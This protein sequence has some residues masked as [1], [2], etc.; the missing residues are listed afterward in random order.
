MRFH[1]LL[2]RLYPASFR[3]EYG[4][5]L[6]RLF[7]ARRRD[8]QAPFGVIA[9][10]M[11]EIADTCVSAARVHVDILRQDLRHTRRSLSRSRGFALA[12]IVVTALGVGATTA[13]F[14]VADH[15]LLQ[16]LPFAEPDR[17]VKIW[18]STQDYARMDVSPANYRDWKD[19]ARSF[20]RMGAYSEGLTA[21]LTGSGE[22]MRLTGSIVTADLLPVL[23]VPPARGRWFTP[24]EDQPNAPGTVL[25]SDA[26]WRRQF[27]ADPSMIGRAIRL[28]DEVCTVIGIMPASFR[29][30]T[31]ATD[32]W[33]ASR[34][35]A[36]IFADRNNNFLRAMAR[37][38]P[39]VTRDQARA[40]LDA[41]ARD[42]AREY[43][44]DNAKV[45]ATMI[46]M[47]DEVGAQSRLLL[48]TLLGASACI[49][50]IACTNLASLLIARAS[51]REREIAVRTALGAGR[52][53]LVRQLLTESGV[54]AVM[55]GVLGVVFALA[56]VP[57][58]VQL[59]PTSL[60][61][62]EQP[63]VSARMLAIAAGLTLLTGL[64]FGVLPALRASRRTA[65]LRDGVRA[66]VSRRTERL[67][68]ALV[69]AQ[70]AVSVVLLVGSGLMLRALWKVQH[71]DPGFAIDNV[72]TLR[73][74]LPGATYGDQ[75]PRVAFYRR[76]LD[77]VR[78]VPGVTGAAFASWLP[79]TMRGG[80]WPVFL[81]GQSREP[82][83][84][85]TV[86]VRYIT[87]DFFSVLHVPLKLGRA[88]TERDTINAEKTAIV[89]ESFAKAHWP[90]EDPRGKTFFLAFFDRTVVG[91]A[92][93]VRVRGLER[94]S[95][96][97]VYLPY[98]QQLDNMMTFYMPKDLAIGVSDASK[99]AG[100]TA[101]VRG[102]ISAADPALP[103]AD[104]RP[105]SAIVALD[106]VARETQVNV[107]GAFA[108]LACLLAAIGLHGLLAFIVAA[109]SREMGVRLALG[110]APAQV[111]WL[112]MQR[113]LMLALAGVTVG[114]GLALLAG[115]SLDS[116]LSGVS[117]NDPLS[118]ATAVAVTLIGA[119]IGTVMPARRAARTQPTEALRAD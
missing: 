76:V 92:G 82:A 112:V 57:L 33:I 28:N 48:F 63:G 62:A 61:I 5:E 59:V 30:P 78:A 36:D 29:F 6:R 97:Q 12:A 38:K 55:G 111:R 10:W 68:G 26:L 96:P 91:V 21:S 85:P 101:A 113:G 9:L 93:N 71:V 114:V 34:F 75:A 56:A 13:A 115:R 17:I 31:R 98:Q 108:V 23:G 119:M 39:G 79:M 1:R 11:G 105:L 116:L 19:R 51:A 103:I 58:I 37:L 44:A 102:I 77:D 8:A 80:I 7:V 41:I 45:G 40:E 15:V 53:R 25:I 88:F 74:T 84:A 49:L 90:G 86:S 50:L 64:G 99:M 83:G 100:V 54:I 117:P 24:D 107:L 94:E 106:S 18:S 22:P 87:D 2:L 89:S 81:P 43:P 110:A 3:N 20:S 4:E 104:V 47:R 46:D 70:V 67:R 35:D 66:G 52:E 72:L 109:R 27:G 16:P 69:V 118:F 73:T 95:E 60:P 14:T 65:A 42:L 32:F